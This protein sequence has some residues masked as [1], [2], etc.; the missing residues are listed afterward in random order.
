VKGNISK[1]RS[2]MSELQNQAATQKRVTKPSDDP[3]AASRVLSS[4]I[5]LQGNRQFGKNLNYARSFL[6]YTDQSLGDLTEV[7]MRAKELAL[8]QSNDASSSEQSRRMVAAEVEQLRGQL[9]S[10]G[11]RKLGDR[12]IF[13]GFSTQVAPFSED[14]EYSGDSGEMNIHIDKETF[15]A[16]NVPGGRVFLGAGVDKDGLALKGETQPKSIEELE[17]RREQKNQ[18]NG[19]QPV[20]SQT[21]PQGPQMRGPASV[22][23]GQGSGPS[24]P[25]TQPE[26]LGERKG[27][28]LFH[29][30]RDLEISLRTNDKE[31]IQDS[32]D[33]LDEALQQVVLTRAQVGSR[34]MTL[35]QLSQT[36]EKAKVDNQATISS[37]EDA[38][39][40]STVSDINKTESTLQ[41]TLQTSGKL[42][43]P[44]LLDF[45]R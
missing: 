35:D 17:Q 9:S 30:L 39:I 13:G 2:Q 40:F 23:H 29:V 34:S 8:S 18:Q 44:S 14:G 45:L 26:D 33:V 1:N 15:I 24:A 12:F 3:L 43:Q 21:Q 6:E 31:G 22:S 7:V 16:M 32:L 11:N 27:L 42:I 20:E 38:D 25:T 4:R 10:I 36:L 41:A 37:L 19:H 28:N 5:D